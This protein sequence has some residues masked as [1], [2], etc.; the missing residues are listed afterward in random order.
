MSA[1]LIPSME[2]TC[3]VDVTSG[4]ILVEAAA[5]GR[6]TASGAE[7]AA[8]RK[9]VLLAAETTSATTEVETG[10]ITMEAAEATTRTEGIGTV[11]TT[12]GTDTEGA[13]TAGVTMTTNPNLRGALWPRL[14]RPLL[15]YLYSSL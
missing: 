8:S 10:G 15:T 13:A 1:C 14:H 4:R 9:A 12:E 5:I 2:D 3:S 7:E 6:T 11:D